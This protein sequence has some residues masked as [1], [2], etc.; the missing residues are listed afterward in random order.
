MVFSNPFLYYIYFCNDAAN[1]STFVSYKS[2]GNVKN[3]FCF[4]GKCPTHKT[5]II[6]EE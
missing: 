1:G 4:G 5:K 6:E 3:N 2:V